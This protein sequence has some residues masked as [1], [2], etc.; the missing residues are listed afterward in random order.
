[1]VCRNDS[2]IGVG[3]SIFVCTSVGLLGLCLGFFV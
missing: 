1:M 3:R 2:G